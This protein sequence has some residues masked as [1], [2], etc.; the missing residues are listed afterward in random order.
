MTWSV[1]RLGVL[2]DVHLTSDPAVQASWHNGYDFAG[3]SG[4]LDEA[5]DA[6]QS[7]QVDA[8]CLIG[9]LT[10]HGSPDGLGPLAKT[11]GQLDVPVIAVAGNHDAGGQ[12]MLTDALPGVQPATPIGQHVAGWRIAGIQVAPGGWFAARAEAPPTVEEW[13]PDPVVLLSHFPLLSHAR[14]LAERGMPYP[15]DL[16]G[17]GT[18]EQ[19]LT[20]RPAPTIVLS[21]HIH[22]RASSY[23]GGV[24]QIIQGA[25]VEAPYEC[26]VIEL[27]ATSVTRQAVVLDGPKPHAPAPI[28]VDAD[29]H[30]Q[31]INGAWKP[32]TPAVPATVTALRSVPSANQSRSSHE[33]QQQ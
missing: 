8:V 6:F 23:R 16:L 31:L 12:K 7:S 18:I 19:T 20:A 17:R 27:T 24:L 15:G 13:G 2:G 30:F 3:L 4:R 25:L 21:G 1:L 5:V 9:D 32:R 10:H 29:E 11:L 22:A 14:R 28:L 26:T 33:D